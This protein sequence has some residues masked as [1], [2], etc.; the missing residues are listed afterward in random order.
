V[1]ATQN[2]IELEGTFPLPEA[3][4]DRF[5]LKIKIGYP[6]E[7]EENRILLRFEHDDPLE[8]LEAVTSAEELLTLEEES[9][10]IRVE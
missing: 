9:S 1:L 4:V 8:D 7:E 5:M 6:T 10:R 3:Q 2:P